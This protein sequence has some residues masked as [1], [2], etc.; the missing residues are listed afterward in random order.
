MIFTGVKWGDFR[1]VLKRFDAFQDVSESFK[2]IQRVSG[3]FRRF[4]RS[5]RRLHML[6]SVFHGEVVSEPDQ[7][8]SK[9]F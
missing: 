7:M 4:Q 1:G 8:V 6:S 3:R 2:A 9:G 5:F